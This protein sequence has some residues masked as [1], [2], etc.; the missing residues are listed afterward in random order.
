ML[1]TIKPALWRRVTH[2]VFPAILLGMIVL[3]ASSAFAATCDNLISTTLPHAT[4]TAAAVVP[5]GAF[6]PPIP[7][8]GGEG[9]GPPRFDALPAFCRVTATAKPTADSDI[10]IEVWLPVSG[11]N[12]KLQGTGNG[13]FG[14]AISYAAMKDVLQTNTAAAA[15]DTGHDSHK[16]CFVSG[17]G[18]FALGHPEKIKD[19]GA[20]AYHEMTVDAKLLVS[21]FYGNGPKLSFLDECG[22]GSREAMSEVQ[23]YPEDWDAVAAG[24][25][26]G[27][28]TH[29]VL[30]QLWAWQ[31]THK[32]EASYI[33]PAK[34]PM[35]HDA[36]LAECDTK[37]GVKDG[38]IAEPS[39]CKFDP[40]VLQCK[41]ADA[42]TCLTAPQ[43]EAARTLYAAPTN[44][45][46][47]EKLFGPL[48]PGSELGWGAV[49]GPQP[50]AYAIDFFKYAAFK[51]PNWDIKTRP[52]NFDSDVALAD[53]EENLVMNASDPDISKFIDRGG[54]LFM[55]GGWSDT[56]VAPSSNSDYFDALIAKMD[57]KKLRDSVRFYMVPGMG[58][59]PGKQGASAFYVNTSEIIQD[60]KVN[61]KAPDPL[62]ATHYANG[63]EDRKVLIC[64][65]PQVAVYKGS[66]DTK[67]PGNF[68]CKAR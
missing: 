63:T 37:D 62:I 48:Y 15:T 66:G 60:W 53:A 59:C 20:R 26:V 52:I 27:Y 5:A 61:G 32:T 50:F 43:V 25:L 65:Y 58:H 3:T 42:P 4:V 67:D 16:G 28:S 40:A 23:R 18:A 10:K 56:P 1:P 64:Q 49:A 8:G 36:A 47:G 46:T 2:F 22:G 57:K 6:M 45:R 9:G 13:C 51:D 31:A 24:G 7:E 30:A 33:P 38:V 19:F 12:G 21:A 14:G 41:G 34:Y 54:K 55:I 39:R 29:H 68:S 35:I 11:W 44:P 17:D